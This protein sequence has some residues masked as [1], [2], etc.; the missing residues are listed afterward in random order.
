MQCTKRLT[1]VAIHAIPACALLLSGCAA[2]SDRAIG[3]DDLLST[4]RSV[5]TLGEVLER[6]RS[7]ADGCLVTGNAGD[8][9]DRCKAIRDIIFPREDPMRAA[10]P[11]TPPN[12][13]E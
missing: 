11:L 3:S 7:T 10:P 2:P 6:E 9:S 1:H 12:Q 4:P 8:S 5:E 13:P